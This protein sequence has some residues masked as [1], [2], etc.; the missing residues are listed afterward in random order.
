MDPQ[1]FRSL[2]LL[3]EI[4]NNHSPSQRDLAQKLNISLGLVNS[5]IKRLATKGYVKIT[6]IPRNRVKYILTP[7]GF[8]EKSRLT[9]EFIQYSFHFYKRALRDIEDL[10]NDFQE[11]GVKKV[12]LYGANDLAEIASISLRGT[13]IKLIGVAD[14]EK[15]GKD[16]L[17][18]TVKSITELK[19]AG[20]DRII[21]TT[22]DSKEAQLDKLL[23]KRI[24]GEKIVMLG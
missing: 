14:E 10:L 21:V 13:D 24:P 7:K 5:F 15:Q 19:K 18:F 3:E 23:R 12:V 9:Y 16:F 20:F 6:T 11:R 17:G 4:D 2:Q 22:V 1:D 8:A